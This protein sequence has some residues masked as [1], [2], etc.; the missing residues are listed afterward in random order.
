M[1][2]AL[3]VQ[4]V[5]YGLTNGALLALS[6]AGFTLT[7]A[8]ARQI[9]LAHGS[10]FALCTVVVTSLAAVFGITAATP[11]AARLGVLILLCA[12]GALAG[13]ALNVGVE[14][15]AFRPFTSVGDPLG[16]LVAS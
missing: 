8:V 14:R 15:L 6:A 3:A 1:L 9:N 5:I 12:C 16:P 2:P 11:I 10:A 4:L 7:Y 13:A